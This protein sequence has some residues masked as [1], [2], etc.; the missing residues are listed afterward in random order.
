MVAFYCF[1]KKQKQKTKQ[2]TTNHTFKTT[3]THTHTRTH[4]QNHKHTSSKP[5][6]VQVG[7]CSLT[8]DSWTSVL[9]G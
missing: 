8:L 9:H 1:C 5:H 2:K 7:N 3:H 6:I 4:T